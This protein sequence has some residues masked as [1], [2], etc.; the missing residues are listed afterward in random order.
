ME[1]AVAAVL[2]PREQGWFEFLT[3]SNTIWP[4]LVFLYPSSQ[5]TG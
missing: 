4:D 3:D 1:S 5:S 2:G